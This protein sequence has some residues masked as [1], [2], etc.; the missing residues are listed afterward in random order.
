[1][2]FL[3]GKRVR[4]LLRIARNANWQSRD[5]SRIALLSA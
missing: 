5:L 4:G 1:M 2:A 3:L